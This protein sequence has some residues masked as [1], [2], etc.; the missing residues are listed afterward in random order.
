MCGV[1]RKSRAQCVGGKGGWY[2]EGPENSGRAIRG[3]GPV[4]RCIHPRRAAGAVTLQVYRF[5][6]KADYNA[7]PEISP[8]EIQRQPLDLVGGIRCSARHH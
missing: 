2:P 5:M 6:S 1:E 4:S 7:L 8:P 3:N